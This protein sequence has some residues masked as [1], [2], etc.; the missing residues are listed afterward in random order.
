MLVLDQNRLRAVDQELKEAVCTAVVNLSVQRV[1]GGGPEGRVL[2]GPSPRR[3]VISGQLLPRFDEDGI[4]D[5]TTDIRI[6]ALGMDFQIATEARGVAHATPQFS[7]YIRVLPSWE[8]LSSPHLGLEPD[9]QLRSDIQSAIDGR[10]RELRERKFSEAGVATPTWATLTPTQ[11]RTVHE[12]RDRIIGEVVREAHRERGILLRSEDLHEVQEGDVLAANEDAQS[13]ASE[14]AEARLPIGR[15]L[16]SGLN[17]PIEL[18]DTAEIPA[19]WV[20]LDF[21]LPTFTWL[22]EEPAAALEGL[23]DQYNASIETDCRRQV[24]GW[25][26]SGEGRREAWKDA[27]IRPADVENRNAWDAFRARLETMP[28]PFD[29]LLPMLRVMLQ[30]D[31]VTDYA[32]AGK[33]SVRALLDNR[34]SEITRQ[35]AATRCHAAFGTTLTL[36]IP[37]AAHRPLHLDRV[38]PSYRFRHFLNYS[39]IGLNNGVV[40]HEH[41]G[42][43]T[44]QTTWSPTFVQPRIIPRHL[45]IPISFAALGEPQLDI[46]QLLVLPTEYSK[47]IKGEEE[48]LVTAVREGLDTADAD[49]ESERLRHDI[50]AQRVEVQFIERGVRLLQ[51][52]QVAYR[53]SITAGDQKTRDQLKRRGAPYQAWLL[54]NQAFLAREGDDPS[55][56]WHL[57][58]LA[59]IIAHIPTLVS[60][61]EEYRSYQNARLDEDTASLLYFPT[62]GGK[63]E[64]FYGTLLFAMFLDRLRGKQRGVTAMIRYPLRLL[65]L[66]QG[67]RLLRLVVHAEIL[68]KRERIGSWP[69]EIG[70]WVG[71]G[72]TPNRY[73]KVPGDV[74]E[75]D[76]ASFPDDAL[77][78]EGALGLSDDE[79]RVA[80]RYREFRAAYN[81]VPECPVCGSSTGLRRFVNEGPTARRLGIVCFNPKCAYGPIDHMQHLPFLLTDDTIYERAP[82][83]VLGTIDKMALLGHHTSTIRQLLGMFGLARGI[84]PTGHLYSPRLENNLRATLDE[85]NYRPVYPTFT[86]GEKVFF[87]PFPSLIIQDDELLPVLLTSS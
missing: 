66:Q 83:V 44:L 17:I 76:D 7:C 55:R 64:A 62:G 31:R 59:F 39:A 24:T 86:D 80:L 28:I 77:L 6:A 11:K 52:A 82:A 23:L 13:P 35:E 8:E 68:R 40:S 74:P 50:E 25:L 45:E 34:S 46:E 20:R 58:Q 87:D 22:L 75:A 85:R 42:R 57:F 4:E 63:S 72:N 65:T 32:D 36:D 48:R 73:S 37:S 78:E 16:R 14:E 43:L 71:S 2:Y 56:A 69:F 70:F 51:E 67:Q 26:D 19:K 41:E 61:M 29:R 33:A 27:E 49:A 47:W 5:E 30:I 15:L 1:S 3:S 79:R 21:H 60:R 81:K 84:G 53:Q 12:T 9:F 54:T 38:E 10:I 18:L